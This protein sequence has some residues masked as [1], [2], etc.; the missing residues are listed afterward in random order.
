[1]PGV[2]PDALAQVKKGLKGLFS[3]KK[4]ER[5][6]AEQGAPNA[7]SNTTY[8][9]TGVTNASIY[10]AEQATRSGAGH[11]STIPQIMEPNNVEESRNID[12]NPASENEL[13][14]T[15]VDASTDHESLLPKLEPMEPKL[16]AEGMS[17]TSGPLSD[18]LGY[19]GTMGSPVED[20]QL[21]L[22]NTDA[23]TTKL[24]NKG[25]TVEGRETE[26]TAQAAEKPIAADQQHINQALHAE[27][28]N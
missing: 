8:S 28:S 9:S 12:L 1:M 4:R 14:Q 13:E 6:R 25:E 3:R 20:K 10:G 5:S 18:D 23:A 22:P 15:Q 26:P 11:D 7:S 16:P 21:Q 24:E 2:P 27:P 17:A 19:G